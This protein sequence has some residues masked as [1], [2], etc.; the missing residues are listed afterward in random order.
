VKGLTAVPLEALAQFGEAIKSDIR[1][2]GV[3]V[4]AGN[5]KAG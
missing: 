3:I 4:R 2:R 5:I 1:D